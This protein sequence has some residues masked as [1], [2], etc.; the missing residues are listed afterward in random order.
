[1][2]GLVISLVV[3]IAPAYTSVEPK[4][5]S[6]VTTAAAPTHP[7]SIMLREGGCTGAAQAFTS[8]SSLVGTQLNDGVV[9][10]KVGDFVVL[11][12]GGDCADAFNRTTT[13]HSLAPSR[14]LTPPWPLPP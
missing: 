5:V 2:A 12:V 1:M 7:F 11:K 4:E 6:P 13:S 10:L 9:V 8:H 3:S 14:W